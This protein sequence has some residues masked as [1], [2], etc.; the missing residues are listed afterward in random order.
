M[1]TLFLIPARGGSKRLPNKNIKKLVGKPLLNY[2]IDVA[3]E[4]TSDD[5]ICVSTDSEEIKKVAESYGLKVPFLRPAKFATD[6]ATT[7][8]VILHALS[9]Y[10]SLGLNYDLVVLL[11]PTSPLR[12]KRHILDAIKLFDKSIEMV[13]SVKKSHSAA[14][15]CNEN[16]KGFI[17]L[18]FNKDGSRSQNVNSFYEYNGSIYVIN[19]AEFL[20]KGLNKLT[21]KRKMVMSDFYSLDIDTV[22]D[23]DL[24]E[25]L[26]KKNKHEI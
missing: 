11:Q 19:V 6:I 7:N 1:K 8:D 23:F 16:E 3:R 9:F 20:K 17:E 13:V 4:I 15:L 18:T 2:S 21:R 22:F 25:Y 5:N 14:V 24:V 12:K 26:I 10:E